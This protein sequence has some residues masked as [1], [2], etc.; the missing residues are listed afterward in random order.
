[1]VVAAGLV[2]PDLG[3]TTYPRIMPPHIPI[4][5]VMSN[6]LCSCGVSI[7][8]KPR[9]PSSRRSRSGRLGNDGARHPAPLWGG[10]CSRLTSRAVQSTELDP[11]VAVRASTF[12]SFVG[13]ARGFWSLSFPFPSSLG[14]QVTS[15]L[16]GMDEIFGTNPVIDAAF[17]AHQRTPRSLSRSTRSRNLARLNRRYRSPSLNRTAFTCSGLC[18]SRIVRTDVSAS[19]RPCRYATTASFKCRYDPSS[20]AGCRVT[21]SPF[22]PAICADKAP[23]GRGGRKCTSASTFLAMVMCY[24][25]AITFVIASTTSVGRATAPQY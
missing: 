17:A 23:S 16:K 14:Q 2:G 8:P 13:H 11:G 4:A 9:I 15:S 1:M 10:V 25:E 6:S 21:I 22:L 18:E 12:G 7:M 5:I 24:R 20:G 3:R 19:W